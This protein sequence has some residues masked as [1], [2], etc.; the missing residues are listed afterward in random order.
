MA[1]DLKLDTFVVVTRPW[2]SSRTEPQKFWN[3]L[4]DALESPRPSVVITI[5][6]TAM[7]AVSAELSNPVT[8]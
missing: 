5:V 8:Y 6:I 4:Q 3:L 2:M 1:W 7:W